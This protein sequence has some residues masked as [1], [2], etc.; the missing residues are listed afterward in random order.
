VEPGLVSERHGLC[1][2]PCLHP[3]PYFASYKMGCEYRRLRDCEDKITDATRGWEQFKDSAGCSSLSGQM[4]L[5]GNLESQMRVAEPR[6]GGRAGQGSPKGRTPHSTQTC[7]K[8]ASICGFEGAWQ[9]HY[10]SSGP[11]NQLGPGP[12]ANS[13]PE[14]Y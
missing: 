1:K 4:F 10:L 8:A 14:H 11:L 7:S 2:W 5:H 3:T 6:V 12:S 9:S 13:C